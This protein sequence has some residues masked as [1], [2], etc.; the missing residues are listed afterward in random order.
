LK[1]LTRICVWGAVFALCGAALWEKD[2]YDVTG[3]AALRGAAVGLALGVVVGLLAHVL[4]IWNRR[5]KE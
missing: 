4:T 1:M 5:R 2:S 3:G